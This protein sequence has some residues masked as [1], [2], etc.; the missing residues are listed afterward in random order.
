MRITTGADAAPPGAA[1]ASPHTTTEEGPMLRA[2]SMG[3]TATAAAIAAAGASAAPP[4]APAPVA[5]TVTD[6]A[7]TMPARVTGGMV[8]MRF[9]NAGT[10]LHEF[11][12]A[13][14]DAGHGVREARAAVRRGAHGA[15]PP[16]GLRDVAG[17]GNL[18]AGAAV[19]VTRRLRPGVYVLFDGVPDRRGVPGVARGLS[20]VFRVAGDTGAAPPAADAVVTARARRFDVPPLHAGTVTLELRVAAG[21]PRGFRL[22]SLRPGSTRADANRWIAAVEGS[23]RLPA[24]PSPITMLGAIQTIPDGASVWVTLAL[25][26]G[27]T[28]GLG[29]DESGVQVRFAPR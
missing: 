22:T 9:A 19:T 10:R 15:P 17:P 3:A 4:A 29:D 16:A 25:Q 21:A 20:R 12:M 27:R 26:A 24:G 23:G 2:L 13:R 8:A 5:V 18:T 28:Y 7:I 6:T 1:V 11:A 14:A